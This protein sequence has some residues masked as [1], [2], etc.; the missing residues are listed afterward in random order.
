MACCG[1]YGDTRGDFSHFLNLSP[2]GCGWLSVLHFLTLHWASG[3]HQKN[4]ET[5]LTRNS[6]SASQRSISQPARLVVN[7]CVPKPL[8]GLEQVTPPHCEGQIISVRAPQYGRLTQ[9]QRRNHLPPKKRPS[10][11]QI[12][13]RQQRPQNQE[14]RSSTNNQS[15]TNGE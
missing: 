5:P 14:L 1:K 4:Q 15:T 8:D 12:K 10:S 11:D 3:I 7:G 6:R 2:R 13:Q 9:Q